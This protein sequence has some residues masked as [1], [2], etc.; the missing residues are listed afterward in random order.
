MNRRDIVATVES[1]E[2][3]GAAGE[4]LERFSAA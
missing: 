3:D 4:L 1:S 2:F